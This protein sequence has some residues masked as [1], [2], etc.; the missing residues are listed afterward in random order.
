MSWSLLL[1]PLFLLTMMM[2]YW[3]SRLTNRFMRW[4]YRADRR[5]F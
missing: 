5:R 4:F 1:V 2:I 3:Y